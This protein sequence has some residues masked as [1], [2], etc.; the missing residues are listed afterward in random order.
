[1]SSGCEHLHV[2]AIV[3]TD[4]A[5]MSV[6]GGGEHGSQASHEGAAV[7]RSDLLAGAMLVRHASVCARA[8]MVSG[9]R[10]HHSATIEPDAPDARPR[11]IAPLRLGLRGEVRRL[12]HRRRSEFSDER[13]DVQRSHR[14][15]ALGTMR[16]RATRLRTN[17]ARPLGGSITP[18]T[19]RSRRPLMFMAAGQLIALICHHAEA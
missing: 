2:T 4:Y 7:H 19:V 12:A 14:R 15:S 9:R 1:M 3:V 8:T 18:M 6:A 16:R 11:A 10:V 13:C 5:N 17:R